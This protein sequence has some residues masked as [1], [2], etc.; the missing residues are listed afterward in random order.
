MNLNDFAASIEYKSEL[1][2]EVIQAAKYLL[3]NAPEAK[4]HYEYIKER[5]GAYSID[6]YNIGFFPSSD[7]LNLITPYISIKDLEKLDLIKKYYAT[8]NSPPRIRSYFEHH[9]L[10]IPFKDEYGNTVALVG[11][12]LLST[13]KQKELKTPKYKNSKPFN[14]RMHLFGLNYAKHSIF[15]NNAAIIVEGQI[16]AINCYNNGYFNV[17]ALAGSALTRWQAFL[18]SKFTT[19]L[20]LLL[21][22]DNA[23]IKASNK[24]VKSRYSKFFENIKIISLPDAYSDID[25]YLNKSSK[26]DLFDQLPSKGCNGT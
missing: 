20:Y 12:T 26:I 7:Q 22:N 11:R 2:S 14:K 6:K 9:N 5:L 8:S 17:V 19:N 24:I 16:D 21:D 3:K 4:Q 15:K 18:L 13:E 10:I 1:F 23:G 25:E